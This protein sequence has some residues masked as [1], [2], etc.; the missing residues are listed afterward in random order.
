MAY[1]IILTDINYQNINNSLCWYVARSLPEDWVRCNV[2]RFLDNIPLGT[3]FPHIFTPKTMEI[4][5]KCIEDLCDDSF[6]K[7]GRKTRLF[8]IIMGMKNYFENG[9]AMSIMNWNHSKNYN[10]QEYNVAEMIILSSTKYI[11]K[12]VYMLYRFLKRTTFESLRSRWKI[13]WSFQL[14]KADASKYRC[15]ICK[16]LKGIDHYKQL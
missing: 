6:T 2:V 13:S 14:Y 5:R 12:L 15:H 4:A 11:L 3:E 10:I 8:F 1:G 9:L 7:Y 16:H